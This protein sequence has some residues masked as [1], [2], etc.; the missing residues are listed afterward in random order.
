M[1]AKLLPFQQAPDVM[2]PRSPNGTSRG[3][4]VGALVP[5]WDW[6]VVRAR[7]ALEAADLLPQTA[8]VLEL[9]GALEHDY[10]HALWMQA[11]IQSMAKWQANAVCQ[12]TPKPPSKEMVETPASHRAADVSRVFDSV[13]RLDVMPHPAWRLFCAFGRGLNAFVAALRMALL[14]YYALLGL[15]AFPLVASGHYLGG[16]VIA[17]VGGFFAWMLWLLFRTSACCRPS[18]R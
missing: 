3:S 9:L 1:T 13:V 10:F 16:A 14:A 17:A 2:R 5:H 4:E 12:P 11:N 7:R 6:E 8:E 18:E 15:A